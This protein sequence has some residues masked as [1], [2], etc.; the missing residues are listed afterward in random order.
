[1]PGHRLA[2]S[3]SH[4]LLPPAFLPAPSSSSFKS[5]FRVCLLQ[6]A[7]YVCVVYVCVCVWVRVCGVSV[8]GVWVCGVRVVCVWYMYVVCVCVGPG[9][10]CRCV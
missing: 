4:I 5:Q 7:V 9:V 10:V 1:M 6:E 2:A 3:W 8:C